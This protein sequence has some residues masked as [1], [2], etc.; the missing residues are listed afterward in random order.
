MVWQRHNRTYILPLITRLVFTHQ[1][2][3]EQKERRRRQE[4]GGLVNKSISEYD[5]AAECGFH[6]YADE[7]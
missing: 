2:S 4:E 3:F 7:F 5:C 1:E 6:V